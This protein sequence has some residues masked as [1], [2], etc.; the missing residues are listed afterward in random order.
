MKKI[1][2][3]GL[4]LSLMAL[5]VFAVKPAGPSAVNGLNGNGADQLYLYE[6]D[7][8]DWN[9]VELWG[10]A[11]G[12][13][14]YKD[15][16]FVFNGHGLEAGYEYTLVRYEGDAWSQVECLAA[17]TT[18]EYGNVHLA[19]DVGSYGDKV[20]LVLSDDVDCEAVTPHMT[21]WN[22]TEYLFEYNTI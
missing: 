9:N 17:G 12:K 11:W 8:T 1:F 16:S 3:F 7:P 19:G 14:N 13:M 6:K 20:W 18:D 10:P 2:V 22:P 5:S 15:D 21:S 4:V